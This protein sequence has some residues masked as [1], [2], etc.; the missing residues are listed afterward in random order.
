[1]MD[2]KALHSNKG[3]TGGWKPIRFAVLFF[4]VKFII[5]LGREEQEIKDH[6]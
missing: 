5:W 3:V 1:M 2:S 6:A 4:F